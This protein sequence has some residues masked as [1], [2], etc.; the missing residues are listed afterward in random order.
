MESYLRES[1][2]DDECVYDFSKFETNPGYS[3]ACK[4]AFDDVAKNQLP[5]Y[6]NEHCGGSIQINPEWTLHLSNQDGWWLCLE[7][8]L[9]IGDEL[10]SITYSAPE[11]KFMENSCS[12][13]TILFDPEN[14][15]VKDHFYF[16]R[17]KDSTYPYRVTGSGGLKSIFS[18]KAI[19]SFLPLH[20]SS[21]NSFLVDFVPE[22]SLDFDIKELIDNDHINSLFKG[23][24]FVQSS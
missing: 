12:T 7:R 17:N 11:S 9:K 19:R 24:P 6:Y 20:R 8:I 22:V 23:N 4:Y 5:G 10:I 2:N 18:V 13:M 1:I 16:A 15:F 21:C 14:S 3:E